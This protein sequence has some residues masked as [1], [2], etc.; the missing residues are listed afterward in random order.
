V[1]VVLAAVG[2]PRPPLAAAVAE[3][4]ARAARYWPL[5]AHEVREEP[6]RGATSEAALER[7]RAAEGERLLARAPSG[8]VVVACDERGEAW[9]S[10]R[11]AA[12]LRDR[13]DAAQSV[14][15]V[16]GGAHGIAPAVR[17]RRR[18]GSPSRRGRCRTRWRASCSP[19]SSTAR[20]PSSAGNR[21]TNERPVTA[22]VPPTAPAPDRTVEVEG[23]EVRTEPLG[24]SALARAALAGRLP[25]AWYPETPAG[26]DAW[27]ERAEVVRR[28]FSAGAW[29]ELLAPALDPRG[30]AAARL[31]EVAGG[32]G[33]VVTTGQQPGLFGGPL[34]TLSKALSALALADA[35]Q[36]ATGVPTAPVFWAAT[37]DIDFVEA[38]RTYVARGP[39]VDELAI[40]TDAPEG[41]PMSDVPL[42][43]DVVALGDL[44]RAGGG[45]LAGE[46]ALRV[47]LEAYAPGATVGGAYVALLRD[48]LEPLGIAVLDASHSAVRDGGFQ[49]LR[50]ALLVSDRVERA[51]AA[52]GGEIAAA[53]FAP[54]VAD[55]PGRSLVFRYGSDGRKSRVAVADARLLVPRVGR[56]ELG[57]NVLL[58]PVVERFLLPTLAYVAG[59]GE[60][61]YFAQVS[62]VATAL[63]VAQ[64]LA[65]P[66]WSGTVIEP[67]VQRAL[68]RLGANVDELADSDDLAGR[69][70]RAR[71][72]P[73]MAEA[74]SALRSAVHRGVD[75]VAA[76]APG[77]GRQVLDGARG[78]LAHRVDRLERR[79]VAAEKRRDAAAARDLAMAAAALF[80]RGTRQE[81]VLNAI[82]LLARHGRRSSTRCSKRRAPTSR[83]WSPRGR[84]ARP[85]RVDR[86]EGGHAAQGGSRDAPGDGPAEGRRLAADRPAAD[87]LAGPPGAAG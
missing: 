28:Q 58:R 49:L 67:R 26:A 64:P 11:F 18:C 83:R 7:V 72:A 50:R 46:P 8:A 61:A 6:A 31:A 35:V 45:A 9:T 41:T 21:T 5:E 20:A 54:Q 75:Q 47:A 37:D 68:D 84:P 36:A 52:R 53:G 44:L 69:L 17:A 2:R 85:T 40:V 42:G 71:L 12:W 48:L 43:P 19:N 3:Y 59:P 23:L 78:Q 74:L 66:R 14:A 81:R 57:P 56:E 29:Y 30:S 10:A 86:G 80:P 22:P 38:S 82:P 16:V 13:R 60:Y 4:E 1:K 76:A 79:L 87:G 73:G 70:A 25:I 27:R 62:A 51:V 15:F 55:V 32:A 77:T 65:V 34:Y 39:A 63:G 33:V 24:G